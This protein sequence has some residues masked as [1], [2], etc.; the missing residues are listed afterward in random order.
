MALDA[1]VGGDEANS[2]VTVAEASSYFND[3]AYSS[4]WNDF[5]SQPQI[6]ITST[7]LLEWY[8]NWKGTKASETQALH[9]PA[10]DAERKSGAEIAEDYIPLE[11]KTAVYEL[12]LSSLT[13][14]RT[15]EDPLAG[16][17]RLKVASLSITADNGDSNSTAKKVIPEK[18]WKILSDFYYQSGGGSVRL[19]RG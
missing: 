14:D 18:V 17:E 15:S 11:V 7:S 10:T 8:V 2:Y 16:I 3:R 12:A 1:T 5:D 9:W 13:A 4:L 19:I 6:L